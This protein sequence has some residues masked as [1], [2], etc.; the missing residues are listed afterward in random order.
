MKRPYTFESI[1][2]D[3]AKNNSDLSKR[4]A[5]LET[6]EP[7]QIG[8]FVYRTANVA[9]GAGAG[10]T[11]LPFD[12]A[13]YDSYDTFDLTTYYFTAPYAGRYLFSV[14]LWQST[15]VAATI[16][17]RL[18]HSDANY[19]ATQSFNGNYD[20]LGLSLP[21]K[22]LEGETVQ[23]QVDEVGAGTGVALAGSTTNPYL[24]Y[25]AVELLTKT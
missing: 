18:Q 19:H 10:Y 11:A 1:F 15:P 16:H 4:L 2:N 17:L 5:E 6:W 23:A 3:L 13:L 25:M 9:V 8:C 24:S 22:L 7:P 12:A 14:N 20:G 21:V